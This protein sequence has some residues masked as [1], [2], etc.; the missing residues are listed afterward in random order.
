MEF[1]IIPALAYLGSN[2]DVNNKNEDLDNKYHEVNFIYDNDR[3]DAINK[4]IE[5]KKNFISKSDDVENTNIFNNRI[6][7]INNIFPIYKDMSFKFYNDNVSNI[8]DSQ[9]FE[10]FDSNLFTIFPC[11][12][13]SLLSTFITSLMSFL[14]IFC[15]L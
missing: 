6:K 12:M 7:S 10:S 15:L 5:S 11:V 14:V 9:L 8:N 2:I 3:S 1:G 4:I 13:Y